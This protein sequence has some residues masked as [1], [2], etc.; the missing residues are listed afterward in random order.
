MKYSI[1]ALA[2]LLPGMAAADESNVALTGK[3]GTM[4]IG[5]ELT[6]RLADA[7]NLR[8]GLNGYDLDSSKSRKGV[9]YDTTFR[10]RSGSL[11]GDIFPMPDSSFRIS[12]GV[13][14][15]DNRIDMKAKPNHSG[16]Y[17]FQNHTYTA[18]QIGTLKGQ[19][20]F[21]KGSPY[22]GVGWGNAFAKP[23]GWTF[24]LDVGALYQGKPKFRLST[25]STYCNTNAQCQTDIANQQQDTEDDM[26]SLR[27]YPV[28]TAGA[29]FRF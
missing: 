11:I 9:D 25:N 3:V 17:E 23:V 12:L 18:D 1:L 10:E 16:D 19:A 5:A 27:W 15:N 7:V 8:V 6:A 20:T 29:T 13:F 28:V 21:N 22:I 2:A 4:G 14:Y 24:S 26:R